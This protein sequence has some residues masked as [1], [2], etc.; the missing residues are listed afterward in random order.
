M[1]KPGQQSENMSNVIGE[2]DGAHEPER[3]AK[4][5][6]TNSRAIIDACRPC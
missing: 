6:F 5:D 2:A 4:D 3:K 1:T